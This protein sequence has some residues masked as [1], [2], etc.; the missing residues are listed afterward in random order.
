MRFLLNRFILNSNWA[1]CNVSYNRIDCIRL[2]LLAC[3]NVFLFSMLLLLFLHKTFSKFETVVCTDKLHQKL[4]K[5]VLLK[6]FCWKKSRLKRSRDILYFNSWPLIKTILFNSILLF[7]DW[8]SIFLKL[9]DLSDCFIL[10]NNTGS[11]LFPYITWR[12]YKPR[13]SA[14][15]LTD[16]FLV[17]PS[18]WVCFGSDFPDCVRLRSWQQVS[19]DTLTRLTFVVT[20]FGSGWAKLRRVTYC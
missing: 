11:T 20:Q 14:A 2:V 18:V 13:S 7:L 10:K 19:W 3:L 16:T 9:S 5:I 15:R 12:C 1:Y 6:D 4:L 8:N 17:S